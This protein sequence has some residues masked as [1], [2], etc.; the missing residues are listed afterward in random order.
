MV[1]NNGAACTSYLLQEFDTFFVIFILYLLLVL[2]RLVLGWG[3]KPLETSAVQ[4]VL[5]FF[6]P[7]VLDVDLMLDIGVVPTTIGSVHRWLRAV[8]RRDEET[9]LSFDC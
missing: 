8:D 7:H 9:E 6:A 5:V 4:G 2:K 3:V 1:E